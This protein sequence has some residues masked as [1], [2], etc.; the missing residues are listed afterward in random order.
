MCGIAGILHFD[1][2]PVERGALERMGAA[3]A[4]R[5]PD[6]E[7]LFLDEAG[8]PAVG[9][10]HRR[11]SIID[12]S[13]EAHQPLA[14]EDGRVRA[15]LNGEIYN[16]AALRAEL[17]GRHRFRSRGDTEVL[18]HGYEDEGDAIVARLD[19]MFALA[20]WDGHRRRLLLAR[21]HFGKKPLH[22]WR[23]AR[24]LVF[25]SEIK[26]LL[27]AGVP[28]ALN[29]AALPEYLAL[30]YVPTPATLF[31]GIERLPPA[32]TLAADAGGV[33]GPSTFW[34]LAFPRADAAR[35]VSL[36]QAADE[37]R[38]RLGQAV[39]KRLVADV[40]LGVLLSGGLDSA[41]VAALAARELGGLRTF[42][43]GFEGE[44]SFDERPA[45]RAL[46]AHIVAQ[47]QESVVRPQA[48]ALVET[49][50]THHDEPFGDSSALPTY[51]VAR[52]ARRA[53]TVALNGDG[54]DEAFAGYPRL[55]AALMAE[56]VPRPLRALVGVTARA[57]P[58]ALPGRGL[59]RARRI[60]AGTDLPLGD[61]IFAWSTLFDVPEL[62]RL[63]V[64]A[65]DP[66]R[67]RASY[68]A[69]LRAADGASPLSRLLYLATRTS[70]LDDLLPKMDRM[71]MAHGLE[72][73]SPFLDRALVEYAATLPDAFK[74]RGLRG[75][76]VLREAARGLLPAETLKRRKRGFVVPLGS[77]FRGEL[78]PMLH[79]LLLGGPRLAA[80]V[81]VSEV[82]RLVGEHESGRAN[83]GH[84]LWA[85]LT[86]ELWLRRHRL[87]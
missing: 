58:A 87:E 33:H 71:T 70:L 64:E 25:A 4:H 36:A 82:R 3:L 77:W 75:K 37:L 15:M 42:T 83:H 48:A 54:G 12:L 50:L 29:E 60:A 13:E 63:L 84:R 44:A 68:R 30:G 18:V 28:A 79:D 16:F 8:A 6:A 67:V 81:R 61:R 1:G 21:D 17:E 20:L 39:R 51:L 35:P 59:R 57:V 23:D 49:L 11:L 2:R 27:A 73:R 56:R 5:G 10:V 24:R 32:S 45:A 65:P 14:G 34:D 31:A 72:A 47:H 80:R 53:V 40:P 46:A 9:L 66:D 78:R 43:V 7:G 52:E 69:A 62:G 74:R 38:A 85:L 41:V 26:A 55:H 22:V 19:G 76:R 86:L